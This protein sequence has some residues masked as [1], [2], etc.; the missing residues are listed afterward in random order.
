MTFA[1][2]CDK[3]QRFSNIP[4]SHPDYFTKLVEAKPLATISSKKV[5]NFVWEAII[6][7]FG[8]PQEIVSDNGMQFDSK[9][10]REFCNELG[11]KKN[12]SSVDHPQTNGQ[13]EAVNK[14]IKYN[15]KTKLEEHKSLWVDKHPKVFWVYRMTSR[16]STR[17][18]PFSLAYGVKAMIPVE[19]GIPSLQRETYGKDENHALMSYELDI[20]LRRNV[21]LLP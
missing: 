17:E 19:I 15:L 9:E 10:F 18:T 20:Y 11:I 5:Q 3:C 8:I 2:K 12:F 6:C 13:V 7:R 1:R 14:I 21:T 16:T 4:R